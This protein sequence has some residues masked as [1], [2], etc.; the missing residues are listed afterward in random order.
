MPVR[1]SASWDVGVVIPWYLLARDAYS[2]KYRREG[3]GLPGD[4]NG[5]GATGDFTD[6]D[7]P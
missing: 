6:A 2:Q 3:G 1:E 5:P 4:A 7:G